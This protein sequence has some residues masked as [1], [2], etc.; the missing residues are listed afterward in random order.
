MKLTKKQEWF[1]NYLRF[2]S[3]EA[4]DQ[5]ISPTHIGI[6]YMKHLGKNVFRTSEASTTLRSMEKKGLV[7][8]N[9]RGH[10]RIKD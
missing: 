1:I 4:P 10:Y 2:M 9:N 5:F 7:E 3:K 6:Q 8:R